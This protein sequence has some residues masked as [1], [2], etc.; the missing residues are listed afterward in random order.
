MLDNIDADVDVDIK[1][2]RSECCYRT[3]FK[4]MEN[5]NH[6]VVLRGPSTSLWFR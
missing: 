6:A 2:I 3:S 4:F 5:F 1:V